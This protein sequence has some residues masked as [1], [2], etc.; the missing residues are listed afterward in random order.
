MARSVDVGPCALCA[1]DMELTF[2]HLIPRTTHRNSWF[3]KTFSFEDMQRGVD[4]CAD[5]HGAVHRFVPNEKTLGREF[6]TLDALRAHPEIGT[7]VRWVSTRKPRRYRTR[8]GAARRR[9]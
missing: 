9:R 5:C 7:F 2:H 3:K 8:G 4:L 1:R 6:N